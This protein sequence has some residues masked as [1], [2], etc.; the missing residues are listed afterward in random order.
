MA[1]RK[2]KK[3]S[4]LTTF[5]NVIELTEYVLDTP[6]HLQ[7]NWKSEYFKNDNPIVLELA[8]GKGDYTVGLAAKWRDKNYIGIDIKGDRL[9]K[10]AKFALEQ[11]LHNVVFLRTLIEETGMIFGKDEIDEIWITF[12][13]PFPKKGKAKKRLTSP[14]FLNLYRQYLAKNGTIH[15]KTDED[16]LYQYSLE[17]FQEEKCNIHT[18]SD[19]IYGDQLNDERL[20]IKTFYEKQFL[21]EGK[22]IKYIRFSL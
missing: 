3:F 22:K 1:K 2:L 18:F 9:W 16:N 21:E 14:R 19:D 15:L 6:Y 8:C 17:T 12:P 4:E 13:D 11:S 5:A 10:G 20:F 7:G